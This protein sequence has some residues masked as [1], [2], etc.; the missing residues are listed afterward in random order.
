M[1]QVCPSAYELLDSWLDLKLI[2]RATQRGAQADGVVAMA[3]RRKSGAISLGTVAQLATLKPRPPSS[4]RSSLLGD[5]TNGA[6]GMLSGTAGK[7]GGGRARA[8]LVQYDVGRLHPAQGPR[9]VSGRVAV[10]SEV[11]ATR[12][13][14]CA[15]CNK[16][17]RSRGV[18]GGG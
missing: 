12:G 3:A 17:K 10:E 1:R 9:A 5:I 2:G 15:Y 11:Q 14:S 4:P 8:G 7:A 13:S 18:G 16:K 6:A